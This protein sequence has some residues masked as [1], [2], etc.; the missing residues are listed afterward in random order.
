MILELSE[1]DR[2]TKEHL[3]KFLE[4]KCK[5]KFNDEEFDKLIR[6]GFLLNNLYEEE[7]KVVFE[8]N[9]TKVGI[10]NGNI[11]DSFWN[12]DD[13]IF[14][15][16]KLE[17]FDIAYNQFRIKYNRNKTIKDLLD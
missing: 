1:I 5:E 15:I 10:S 6:I 9:E 17:E 8:Y 12:T 13:L 14:H 3:Y 7:Y 2:Y 4:G 11:K 16:I